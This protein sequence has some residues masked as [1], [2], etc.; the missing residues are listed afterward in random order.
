MKVDLLYSG[1]MRF[2]ETCQRQKNIFKSIDH[3]NVFSFLNYAQDSYSTLSLKSTHMF[4]SSVDF[5]TALKY[6]SE[7]L[8]PDIVNIYDRS[9]MFSW[10]Q[11]TYNIVDPYQLFYIQHMYTFIEGLKNCTEDVSICITSDLIIEGNIEL[12]IETVNL[13]HL[14]LTISLLLKSLE[15]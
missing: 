5:E 3:R 13:D 9:Y 6:I 7:H 4:D 15:S 10:F 2:V 11:K 8:S 12:A 14:K 1:Q